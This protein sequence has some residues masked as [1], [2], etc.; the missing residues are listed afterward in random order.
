[1]IGRPK[2]GMSLEE[3]ADAVI[4]AQLTYQKQNRKRNLS[5]LPDQE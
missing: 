1:M 4:S 5:P 2:P 3:W